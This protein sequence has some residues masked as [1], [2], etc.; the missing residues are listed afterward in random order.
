[1]CTSRAWASRCARSRLPEHASKAPPQEEQDD[2]RLQEQ[3]R[4]PHRRR[5]G[6]WPGMRAHRRQTGHEP[7]AG[8]CA[9]GCP[10]QGRS[11]NE[12]RRRPG[13]G[14]QGGRVQRG[15]DGVARRRSERALRRAAFRL[16]QRR[17]RRRR[18]GLGE[19]GQGLGMGA[20]RQRLGRGARR[21][22]VH[23]DDA[24]SRSQ[25]PAVPGPHRQHRQHGGPAEPAQHG[26][27]QRQQACGREP[28]RDAL[29]GP[30]AGDR[31]DQRLCTDAVLRAH[32]HQPEPPQP[33]AGH[34]RCKCQADEEPADRPGHER[35]GGGL[36]Q[37]HSRRCGAEGL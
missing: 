2:H 3:N 14:P 17:R 31:P 7:G 18:P 36:G 23:A 33:P 15:P 10:G 12:G 26:H 1:M 19:L 29:P 16:Q 6:L 21:A 37:G 5:L 20:G 28:D 32:R 25:R 27:L 11:R 24:R 34:G 35:Q 4:R 13:A 8:G 30:G 22:S 9:A